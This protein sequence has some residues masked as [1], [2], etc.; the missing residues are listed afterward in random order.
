MVNNGT[1][2]I[3]HSK[4]FPRTGNAQQDLP[5]DIFFIIRCNGLHYPTLFCGNFEIGIQFEH[6]EIISQLPQ[7]QQFGHSF[8]VIQPKEW[9]WCGVILRLSG[10]RSAK[11]PFCQSTRWKGWN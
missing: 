3:F 2:K 5:V 11:T 7:V 8:L 10:Q 1:G 9:Q 6:A 4:G